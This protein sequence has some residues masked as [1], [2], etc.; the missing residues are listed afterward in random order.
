MHRINWNQ[1]QTGNQ[2][3]SQNEKEKRAPNQFVV[4]KEDETREITQ[5][6]T[7]K[8]EILKEKEPEGN[9]LNKKEPIVA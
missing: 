4:L 2:R 6:N 9:K 1:R 7:M 5:D 3:P 8:T